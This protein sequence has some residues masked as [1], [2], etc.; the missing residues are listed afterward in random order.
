MRLST[1]LLTLSVPAVA[2]ASAEGEGRA[3]AEAIQAKASGYG[4][5][6]V[7]IE[8]ELKNAGGDSAR[9]KIRVSTLERPEG[10]TFSLIVFDSPAD[11]RGTALLSRGEE[12]W[13]YLPASERV[14]RIATSNRTGAFAGSEFSYEDLTS[15]SV[16]SYQ[17]KLLPSATGS[18]LVES[19]PN[20]EASGYSRR[21]MTVDAAS[22]RPEKIEFFDRKGALQKTLSYGDWKTYRGNI[23]RAHRWTMVNHQTG[24]TTTL[25][26]SDF[27]FDNGFSPGDFSQAKLKHVR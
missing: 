5:Q 10:G 3:I 15:T 11:V 19:R 7:A 22:R 24:K 2:H 23:D 1:L 8:M 12:Q 21:V 26:F 14:R 25:Q 20:D 4:D 6:V 16:G 18:L 13:L 27:K 17:W 9:R